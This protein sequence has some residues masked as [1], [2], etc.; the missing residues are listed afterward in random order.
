MTRQEFD[1]K[2]GIE[3]SELLYARAEH[4][5]LECDLFVHQGQLVEFFRIFGEQGVN[6]LYFE[7]IYAENWRQHC[8]CREAA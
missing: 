4:V 2:T 5:Y 6:T 1:A 8:K 3:S 7:V